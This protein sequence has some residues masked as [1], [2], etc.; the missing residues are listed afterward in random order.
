MLFR[1]IQRDLVVLQ[2]RSLESNGV[3]AA[4]PRR[5]RL[6]Q[7]YERTTVLV[8]EDAFGW[9]QRGRWYARSMSEDGGSSAFDEAEKSFG[10]ALRRQPMSAGLWRERSA[11]ALERATQDADALPLAVEYAV[12]TTRRYP[13]SAAV[14]WEAAYAGLLHGGRRTPTG[15]KMRL[16]EMRRLRPAIR[17]E[18]GAAVGERQRNE[19]SPAALEKARKFAK[20]ALEL[21]DATP[22]LDK[23]LSHGERG[24]AK[25]ILANP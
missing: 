17:V 22:H 21:D 16:D 10:E 9:R 2:I 3:P 1:S 11:V 15:V 18:I 25:A 20:R 14:Q 23:K 24:W 8:P 19:T 7:L 13:N 12:S 4:G 6:S 5:E